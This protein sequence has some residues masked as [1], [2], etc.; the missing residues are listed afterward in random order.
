MGIIFLNKWIIWSVSHPAL[1]VKMIVM[2]RHGDNGNYLYFATTNLKLN[3][4]DENID[5]ENLGNSTLVSFMVITLVLLVGYIIDGVE[6]I[7]D[8]ILEVNPTYK[9]PWINSFHTAN[10]DPAWLSDVPGKRDHGDDHLVLRGLRFHQQQL[11][12][13]GV[14]EEL[15]G[16]HGPRSSLHHHLPH[17]PHRL[18]LGLQSIKN[19]EIC[20]IWMFIFNLRVKLKGNQNDQSKVLRIFSCR[21]QVLKNAGDV[22]ER[23]KTT[24]GRRSLNINKPNYDWSKHKIE[25]KIERVPAYFRYIHVQL[26]LTFKVFTINK[27]N[28]MACFPS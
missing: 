27:C 28:V 1:L 16:G 22:S 14:H 21:Y 3:Y 26:L 7:Q 19:L 15:E 8:S 9:S 4:Q 5:V 6:V 2:T 17:L 23:K 18:H 13:V 12:R 25:E 24:T 11:H 10:L 20:V